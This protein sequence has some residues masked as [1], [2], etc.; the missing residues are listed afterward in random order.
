[1]AGVIPIIFASSLLYLPMLVAQFNTPPTA[2]A[3][4][5]GRVDLDVPGLGDQPLYMLCT[6]C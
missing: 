1:M 2:R 6:S 4:R 5:L 3:A